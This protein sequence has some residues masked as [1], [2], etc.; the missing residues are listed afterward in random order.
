MADDLRYSNPVPISGPSWVYRLALI[1]VLCA[2]TA[3]PVAYVGFI[4]VIGWLVWWHLTTNTWLAYGLVG[5]VWLYLAPV[6]AGATAVLFLLKPL[7]PLRL[8][9]DPITVSRGHEPRLFAAIDGVC[10]VLGVPVPAVVHVDCS[11]NAAVRARWRFGSPQDYV[12][13]LGLPLVAGLSTRQLVGVIAHEVAH[14]DQRT[15]LRLLGI[16]H[17]LDVWF[18]RVIHSRA[19]WDARLEDR[20][21][22]AVNLLAWLGVWVSERA[23]TALMTASRAISG[24]ARRQME[25]GA[26]LAQCGVVG[27][28][29]VVATLARARALDVATGGALEEIQ[30]H[31]RDN[32]VPANLPRL[33]LERADRPGTTEQSPA[34]S[35]PPA[36]LFDTHP[37]DGIRGQALPETAG[38]LIGGEQPAETLFSDFAGLC[39]KATRHH[40]E[41]MIGASRGALTVVPHGELE[42]ARERR[43]TRE[44]AFAEFFEGCS[45][46]WRP[47]R[48]RRPATGV[49][50]ADCQAAFF[51]ARARMH[52]EAAG[53]R[54][55][56]REYE[57]MIV[58]AQRACVAEHLIATGNDALQEFG[59][60]SAEDAR[61]TRAWAQG[62]QLEID[63][64]LTEFETLASLRLA[65]AVAENAA[66]PALEVRVIEAL[67]HVAA[68][69]PHALA[70]IF[71]AKTREELIGRW[72]QQN[73]SGAARQR[74]ETI[75][76]E[77]AA[78]TSLLFS[79]LGTA[80]NPLAADS[81]ILEAGVD[82]DLNHA[83]LAAA[84][85]VVV[86]YHDLLGALAGMA[87]AAEARWAGQKGLPIAPTD[88]V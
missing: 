54:P 82:L 25:H 51:E 62:R 5:L 69:M 50:A 80:T 9:R 10:A 61:T 49:T 57:W 58:R 86:V 84:S 41:L 18:A 19:R 77:L 15:A 39:T 42:A 1:G 87:L 38:A 74:L 28:D 53:I 33:V 59:E 72:A 23:V 43:H 45:S 71:L 78:T 3:L 70:V 65:S 60:L 68:A 64:E 40:L 30:K 67:D 88:L 12:L 75:D 22:S 47:I 6:A 26:D 11:V 56:Y 20:D 4:A 85:G 32:M 73:R 8:E 29:T 21:S 17:H 34:Q 14:G 36:S 79:S 27:R 66:G 63:A 13:T 81:P 52:A 46:I 16:V 55:R 24:Y 2:L 31:L 44:N 83:P 76:A 7:V 48:V 37:A 35:A